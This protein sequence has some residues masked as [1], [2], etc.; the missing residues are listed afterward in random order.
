MASTKALPRVREHT[1]D[2]GIDR[3]QSRRDD[4]AHAVNR[5]AIPPDAYLARDVTI[6]AGSSVTAVR[7]KLGRAYK[8][9]LFVRLRGGA[10]FGVYETTQQAALDA[11]QISFA[12]DPGAPA[13]LVDILIW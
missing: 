7:H 10:A 8:N 13:L 9:W 12:N 1:G 6:P 3:A 4:V 5:F 11:S 2:P